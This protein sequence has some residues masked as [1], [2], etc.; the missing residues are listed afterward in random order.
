[1]HKFLKIHTSKNTPLKNKKIQKLQKN[2]KCLTVKN[3]L[4]KSLQLFKQTLVQLQSL[5]SRDVKIEKVK[6]KKNEKSKNWP[7]K[8]RKIVI[9]IDFLKNRSDKKS[10][11]KNY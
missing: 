10:K 4:E 5:S 6:S 11:M 9:E 7:K 3:T 8:D 2:Q 1:M